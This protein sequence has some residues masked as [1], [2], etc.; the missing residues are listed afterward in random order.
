MNK[1]QHRSIARAF[2]PD[3][4]HYFYA[5]SK[6]HSDPAYAAVSALLAETT[7]PILDVG[8]GIG[9]LAQYL[10]A[11]GTRASYT[12]VDNDSR[13]IDSAARAARINTLQHS[14]FL[15]HDL[16][17]SVP[18]HQGNVVILD[19]LHYLAP[20]IQNAL[21]EQAAVCLSPGA[22]LIIRCGLDDGGWR[23]KITHAVDALG[24][25]IRWMN[26][27]PTRYPRREQLAKQLA[28]LGLRAEFRPLWGRTPFNNWL[29][30]AA[31]DVALDTA[32]VNAIREA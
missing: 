28:K 31:H 20:D 32:V 10:R 4:F 2:L 14:R 27:A 7:A 15:V 11:A 19:V 5:L 13:K 24:H 23:S 18:D 25:S 3:R 1:T 21:L 8:C 26:T 17:R 6:L 29:I 22:Q 30:V 16:R 12:G 9:L